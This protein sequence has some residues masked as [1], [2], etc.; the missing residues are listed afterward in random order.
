ML[1]C[2]KAVLRMQSSATHQGTTRISCWLCSER[3]FRARCLDDPPNLCDLMILICS[4]V[5]LLRIMC[6]SS[7]CSKVTSL[8]LCIVHVM[9]ERCCV[10]SFNV[11]SYDCLFD[12]WSA[13][14]CGFSHAQR[15][16]ARLLDVRKKWENETHILIF[17]CIFVLLR[18]I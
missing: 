18:P 17:C 4:C 11:D 9:F 8:E 6:L 1:K 3:A 2:T 15:L 12:L 7:L 5:Y 10:V 13:L 16:K 14:W